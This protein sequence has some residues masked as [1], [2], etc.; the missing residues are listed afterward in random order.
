MFRARILTKAAALVICLSL[1][2]AACGARQQPGAQP[3]GGGGAAAGKP[4]VGGELNLRLAKD[5][6]NFNPILSST[7][8]GSAIYGQVYATLFEFNERWEPEPYIAESLP[9]FSEDGRTLI[10]KIRDGIKFH[11]GG[12]LTA[13]DVVF[14]LNAVRNPDYKGP[15]AANLRPLK[16]VSAPDRLTVRIEL[17]EPYAPV[18]SNINLGILQ[19][20]LFEGTPIGELDKHPVSMNPVGAGPF[21]FIEYRRG[22]FVTLER[23]ENWVMS[24]QYGGAP[25]IQTLRFRIIP[26]DATAQAALEN[27]EIDMLTPDPKDVAHIETALKDR[28]HIIN[29]ERNGWGYITL[30][31]T[32]PHLENKLVRQALGYGLNRQS[33]ID[34]VMDGRAV[35]P[36]GPIPPVSWAYDPTIKAAPHDPA[37]ARQLLE[38][39]GYTRGAGG[40]YEKDGQP[41][42]LTFYGSAG[43]ALIEGLTAIARNNWQ[44]IG[45]DVDVQLMDFNAMMENHLRPGRFDI[46]FSGFSLSLDPD[47]FSLFHSTQVGGFNRGR[48]NSPEV[49]R[50]LEEGRRE[51]DPEK[52]KAIYSQYQRTLVDDTP[53]ILVYANLYT[54]VVNRK[55]KG[56]VVNFPGVGASFIYR[57]WINQQ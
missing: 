26:E 48:Y 16:D 8:F 41:L 21:K 12:D 39:A 34:A 20:R 30:N 11:D 29:Y 33:I 54:D 15:R 56:G 28:F 27:N 45:V 13:E 25:F 6:D 1:V 43:S 53:V 5:P 35:I 24:Q 57:W 2:L 44:E 52:R 23:N 46:S 10:I 19:A 49:D 51:T 37:R 40:F 38:Q 14:T 32:R 7:A 17:T 22:Q 9:Q 3:P 42:K 47:Q 4:A 50:L 18:I 55:V 36:P 31:V